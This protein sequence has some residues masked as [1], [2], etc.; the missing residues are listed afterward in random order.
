MADKE[1]QEKKQKKQVAKAYEQY[2]SQF[3]PKPNY[4]L[5]C[6]KAFLVGG[7]ICVC[8]LLLEKALVGYGLDQKNAGIYVTVILVMIAQLLTG[9]GLFDSIGKFAGAGVIV[10]ITGF[11]NSMV[12]PAIEYKQ[13]GIVL[14]VG[15]KLFSLAGPVL[16]CG[17]SV[18]TVIGIIYW[19]AGQF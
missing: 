14:G 19:I 3:T 12:A 2:A 13:E 15:A 10:P 17:I 6:L 4:F 7:L 5:N 18:A 8:A 1:K 16:V 9:L 11:A